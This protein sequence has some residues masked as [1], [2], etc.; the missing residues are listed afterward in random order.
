MAEMLLRTVFGLRRSS[1]GLARSVSKRCTRNFGSHILLGHLVECGAAN[2]HDPRRLALG[3]GRHHRSARQH[4]VILLESPLRRGF[5]NPRPHHWRRVWPA[6]LGVLICFGGTPGLE[7]LLDEG[8]YQA[9]DKRWF[10]DHAYHGVVSQT[11]T[12]AWPLG[13]LR[14]NWLWILQKVFT[15]QTSQQ[16]TLEVSQVRLADWLS[17]EAAPGGTGDRSA[18]LQQSSETV[19]LPRPRYRTLKPLSPVRKKGVVRKNKKGTHV[20]VIARASLWSCIWFH[21]FLALTW[22]ACELTQPLHDS[23]CLSHSLNEWVLFPSWW[24]QA[25]PVD[26][27]WPQGLS[28]SALSLNGTRL[29]LPASSHVGKLV[30]IMS[31]LWCQACPVDH[32]ELMVCLVDPDDRLYQA[33]PADQ[34]LRQHP[35][36]VPPSRCQACPVG[37]VRHNGARLVLYSSCLYLLWQRSEHSAWGSGRP[38]SYI[39][40]G[41]HLHGKD[42]ILDWA[43]STPRRIDLRWLSGDARQASSLVSRAIISWLWGC[44]HPPR[45]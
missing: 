38:G 29:V 24:C 39:L 36:L 21:L 37:H 27:V 34:L 44:N 1:P 8:S 20:V 19:I 32:F 28:C 15:S 33:C 9:L 35:C 7:E 26:R 10:N 45:C 41:P 25:C 5:S 23:L 12:F 31:S 18:V 16:C 6:S 17:R 2:P 22:L 13:C 4:C 42:R 43:W 30:I 11:V 3:L 40:H 14:E